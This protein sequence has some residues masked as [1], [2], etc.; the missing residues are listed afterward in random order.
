MT[1]YDINNK[2]LELIKVFEEGEMSEKCFQD[3]LEDLEYDKY[4]KMDNICKY[5]KQ[6]TYSIENRQAEIKRLNELN[7]QNKNTIESLRNLLTYSMDTIE[8]KTIQ[9]K[10]F[11]ITKTNT[12]TL[13]ISDINKIPDEF[14]IKEIV[15]N[16]SIKDKKEIIE[17]IKDGNTIDGIQ[18]IEKKGIRIG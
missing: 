16:K 5:I 10:L 1:L 7:K 13:E 12:E 6:L 15:E 4:E 2:I 17:Y 3:T 11:K 9:T 18:I 8:K 14:L